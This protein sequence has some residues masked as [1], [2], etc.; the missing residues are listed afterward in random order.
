MGAGASADGGELEQLRVCE[1]LSDH[2]TGNVYCKFYEEEDAEAVA[3]AEATY[4]A[5]VEQLR[6]Q[7]DPTTRAPPIHHTSCLLYTS[8][9]PRDS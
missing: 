8:P 1:N 7:A 2:L 6:A 5:L 3:L 4:N 9:S